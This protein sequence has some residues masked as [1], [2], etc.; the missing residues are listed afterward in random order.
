MSEFNPYVFDIVIC[1]VIVFSYAFSIV[2][3][4]TN[5]PSVLLL[6]GLGVGIQ[7]ALKY[8]EID[9]GT[10]LFQILEVLGIFGLIM[11]VLEAALDLKLTRDKLPLIIK[12]F[13]IALLALVA[14]SLAIAY[15]LYSTIIPVFLTA[16]V[17]SVPLSV[18][19][20]AIIIPSVASLSE[21]KRE[22][23]I[24]ESTFSDILGIMYFYFLTGNLETQQ[25]TTV[26]TDV[27]SNVTLTIVLSVVLGYLLVWFFQQLN[28]E[29]KLFL[30][31]A[32]LVL[33]YSVGKLFHLSSLVIILIFGLMLNNYQLF[34]RGRLQAWINQSAITKICEE[35]H[36]VTI[37][38]AFVV[39]TFF[40]VVF[41]MTL[42]LNSL[43]D[44]ETLLT[45]MLIVVIMYVIRYI[46]LK[47]ILFRNILPELWVAPRGLITILLFFSIP[48]QLVTDQFNSG[49][50]LCTVLVT[51]LIMTAA[52]LTKPK[53]PVGEEFTELTFEDWEELDQMGESA[54]LEDN[55][56]A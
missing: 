6:I 8:L 24:Y 11:I 9:A 13:S 32:V 16:L 1:L 30:L 45:G 33:L 46:C 43:L 56:T 40:F 44:Q 18:M 49:I 34:F 41:G 48:A 23:L 54:L 3:R 4:K 51:S 12:S 2:S 50:L 28:T 26:I 10:T 31:I 14:T 52:L 25:A 55:N 35:F 53:E 27:V 29:V 17:Y 38:S 15:L 20:S 7:Y 21:H 19:S 37:E 47:S 39:R 36:L 42:E 22:F 5:I